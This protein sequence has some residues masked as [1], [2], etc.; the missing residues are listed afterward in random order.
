MRMLTLIRLLIKIQIH[1]HEVSVISVSRSYHSDNMVFLPFVE[2]HELCN[3]GF[4]VE[5]NFLGVY[6]HRPRRIT[7]MQYVRFHS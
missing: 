2:P 5:Y 6:Q 7:R 1:P 3:E 4:E